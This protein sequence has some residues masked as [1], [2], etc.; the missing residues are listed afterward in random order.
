MP[1]AEEGFVQGHQ[2]IWDIPL[3]EGNWC[4]MARTNRIASTYANALRDEGWI[5]SRFGHPSIPTRMYEAI[6]DWERLCK[7]SELFIPELRNI[8]SFMESE[9][10]VAHGFGPKSQK[11]RQF[12]EEVPINM[13]TAKKSLGLLV[14]ENMRWHEALGKIDDD[15]RNYI[16][17]ALKRGENVKNPRITVST[18]HSMKGGECDNVVVVPDLSRAAYREYQ[19]N[20]NTEHRVYYVA[21]TRAKKSLHIMEPSTPEHY[22]L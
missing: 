20:P 7:G 21:T 17:N 2:N 10:E 22:L 8:Y 13:E 3:H 6:V 12:D 1:T 11:M 19:Q 18:I 4:I 15:N 5:Y 14:N 9:T 16:L